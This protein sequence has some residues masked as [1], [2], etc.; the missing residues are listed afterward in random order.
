MSFKPP[1]PGTSWWQLEETDTGAKGRVS[2]SPQKLVILYQLLSMYCDTGIQKAGGGG[3]ERGTVNSWDTL[4]RR[5]DPSRVWRSEQKHEGMERIFQEDPPKSQETIRQVTRMT[6]DS[7]DL[8]FADDPGAARRQVGAGGVSSCRRTQGSLCA[9]LR[10]KDITPS[11]E[12][13]EKRV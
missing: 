8:G 10:G 6:R 12:S 7:G 3:T 2:W 1:A 9:A 11:M 13:L 4:Q 5:G